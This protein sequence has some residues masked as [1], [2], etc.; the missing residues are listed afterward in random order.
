MPAVTVPLLET[1]A[2]WRF[3]FVIVGLPGL[4]V[5]LLM[6]I[7]REPLRRNLLQGVANDFWGAHRVGYLLAVTIGLAALTSAILVRSTYAP[8]RI[9]YRMMRE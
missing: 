8:Y 5:A 1:I 6:C 2:S 7:V 4:L 9:H 3:T